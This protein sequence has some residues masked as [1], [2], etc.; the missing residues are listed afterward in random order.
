[1]EQTK[2]FGNLIAFSMLALA[3]SVFTRIKGNDWG[4]ET[5]L[6]SL[7]LVVVFYS[8]RFLRKDS[9]RMVDI[10]RYIVVLVWSGHALSV[11]YGGG[12]FAWPFLVLSAA[13]L[14][15][16]ILEVKNQIQG[17][18]S[19][20]ELHFLLFAGL[21]MELAGSIFKVQHWPAANFLL[22]IGVA[23]VGAGFVFNVNSKIAEKG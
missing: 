3:A 15:W 9:K 10:A 23:V 19:F 1:M 22:V 12:F 18:R 8:L 2:H 4:F 6:I 13:S 21:L 17:K 7:G 16:I 11:L 14:F 5:S 20:S